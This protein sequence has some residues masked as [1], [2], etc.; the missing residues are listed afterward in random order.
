MRENSEIQV[1]SDPGDARRDCGRRGTLL[2]ANGPDD[3]LLAFSV[4]RK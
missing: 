2:A 3:G 1:K 4:N